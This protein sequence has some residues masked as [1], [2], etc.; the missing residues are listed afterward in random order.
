MNREDILKLCGLIGQMEGAMLGMQVAMGFSGESDRRT[1]KRVQ[2]IAM[3]TIDRMSKLVMGSE[4]NN[5]DKPGNNN[6]DKPENNNADKPENNNA[7]KPEN[8]NADKP[9]KKHYKLGY[10]FV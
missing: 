8:N 4:N 1:Y 7:D 5:A 10:G 9:E 6:A 2:A 3:D